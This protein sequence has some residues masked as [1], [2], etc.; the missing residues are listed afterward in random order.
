[1]NNFVLILKHINKKPCDTIWKI[2]L[3]KY[4]LFIGICTII[5]D[6]TFRKKIM[7]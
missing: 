4:Y 6:G 2:I 7:F 3:Y 5:D 1:M